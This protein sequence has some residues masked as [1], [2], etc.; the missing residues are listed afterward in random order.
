MACGRGK[1]RRERRLR[2]RRRRCCCPGLDEGGYDAPYCGYQELMMKAAL[3][4]VVRLLQPSAAG[5]PAAQR[6]P[7]EPVRSPAT[8]AS[9]ALSR[10]GRRSRAAG[11][12]RSEET[13]RPD[14]GAE[15]RRVVTVGW[16]APALD[17]HGW[18]RLEV[19]RRG[20]EGRRERRAQARRKEEEIEG[21][22]GASRRARVPPARDATSAPRALPSVGGPRAAHRGRRRQGGG[23]HAPEIAGP[24]QL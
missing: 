13:R 1:R 11:G 16:S 24:H 14:S 15:R 22:E 5:R 17:H 6:R 9:R 23:G 19:R 2:R 20:G 10:P 18:R 12:I 3:R 4:G 21:P 8:A 7:L